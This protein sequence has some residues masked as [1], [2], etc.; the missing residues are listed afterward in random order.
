MAVILAVDNEQE[1]V[2]MLKEFLSE[3][4][5][6]VYTAL[7]GR[8]ALELMKKIRPHIV[9]LDIVMPG[10]D[11]ISTLKEIKKVDPTVGVIMATAIKDEDLAR[12]AMALGAYDYV[13]KPFDLQYLEDVLSV[14]M[15]DILG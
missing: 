1:V 14:K 6:T 12:S 4:D 8:A 2:D 5:H 9:L 3:N 10:M 13:V 11:G 7:N 15:I